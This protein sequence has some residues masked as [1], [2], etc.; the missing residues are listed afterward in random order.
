MELELDLNKSLEEN[1]TNYFEKSK[2]VRKKILGLNKAIEFQKQK[3]NKNLLK[4]E[5]FSNRKKKWFEKFRWFFSSDNFL[6]IGGKN[7]QMNENII[8]NHMKKEDVYFHAEVFGAPHCVI[9]TRDE[10]GKIRSVPQTTL[11]ETAQF[12]VTFSKAFEL[13]QSNADAYSVKPEQ[14]SKRAPTG[15]SLSTGS[16]MIYGERNWFKKTMISFAIGFNQKEKLLMGGPL[17]AV[18]KKCINIIELKQGNKDKNKIA[19]EIQ[20]KFGEKKLFFSNSEILSL[21][22][23]GKIDFC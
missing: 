16:F 12:A 23:N 20:K 15:T 8:K 9:K 7:A 13:G 14:V 18:K 1:A 17:S 5:I 19:L 3:E 2:L 11:I 21:I 10:S 22:P 4:K 6:V